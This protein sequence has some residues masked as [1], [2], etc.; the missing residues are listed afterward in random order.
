MSSSFKENHETW[1]KIAQE[2]E[3]KFLGIDLYNDSYDGFC[4]LIQKENASILE[5]GCGP[6]NITQ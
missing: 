3:D 5:I 6:G 1:N 2:Y 4:T